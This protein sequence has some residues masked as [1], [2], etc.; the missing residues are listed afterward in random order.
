[1]H[2]ANESEVASKLLQKKMDCPICQYEFITPR[3]RMTKVRLFN[4]D[5]DLRPYYE[6]IDVVAYEPVTCPNCGYSSIFKTFYDVTDGTRDAIRAHLEKNYTKRDWPNLVDTQT[7]IEKFLLALQC[8]EPKKASIGEQAYIYLKLSWLFRVHNKV[9]SSKKNEL[10][11]QKKFVDTAEQTFAEVKFP[12]LDWEEPVFLFLI[13]E[14]CRR[15]G[16]YERAYKYIGKI[17]LD[18]SV[19]DKIR[20]RARDVK[21]MI[22]AERPEREDAGLGSFD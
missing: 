4:T 18:R 11:C 12:V 16:D 22:I 10:F 15:V 3:A 17:L 21:E 2:N 20:E 9:D 13:G 6:G 1:M 19:S 8:L 5:T 14:V 7:A